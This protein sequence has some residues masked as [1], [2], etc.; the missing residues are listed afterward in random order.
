MCKTLLSENEEQE[1]ELYSSNLKERLWN[2]DYEEYKL[3]GQYH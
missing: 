2:G 3:A 1:L